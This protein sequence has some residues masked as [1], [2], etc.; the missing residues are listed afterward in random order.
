LITEQAD[1]SGL[2]YRRNRYYDPQK[3]RFTQEDPIGLAGGLNLYGFAGGDPVNFED[4][5]GLDCKDRD[6]KPLPEKSC[7]PEDKPLETP[8]VDPVAIGSGMLAGALLAPAEATV[9]GG[10]AAVRAGQA[11][12]AAVRGVADIGEKVAI[13][14]AGRTRIP[15]GLTNTVLTEVKNVKSLSYT[16]QLR[17]FASYAQANGLRFDLWVR[18]AAELSGPL[19]EAIRNGS[20]NLRIIP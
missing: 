19:Q 13:R 12:E 6:G 20:I 16:Q 2:M 1:A 4:P 3:G 17:D 11:G 7:H 18:K 5:F 15:D 14:V 9:V 8:L 10:I